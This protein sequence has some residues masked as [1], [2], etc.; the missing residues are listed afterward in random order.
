MLLLRTDSYGNHL[1]NET[2]ARTNLYSKGHSLIET[3]DHGFTI[4][5]TSEEST[6]E[7]VLANLNQ[8]S[9]QQESGPVWLLKTDSTGEMV[10]DYY[11]GNEGDRSSFMTNVED[12]GYLITGRT[13]DGDIFL[14]VVPELDWIQ[15]PV[16]Q[17]IS[18][19]SILIYQLEATSFA[20]LL[21]DVNNTGFLIDG[22]GILR[23]ATSLEPGTYG[24]SIIVTDAVGNT[25][26]AEIS[27]AVNSE[28]T[29]PTTTGGDPTLLILA[30]AGIGGGV[31]IVLL[32]VLVKKRGG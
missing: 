1:W 5:G 4:V 31:A 11:L 20:P 13:N 7:F 2:F 26:T 3:R 23:N 16:N 32:V 12:G 25:L 30:V 17:V 29:T 19:N 21:W 6:P 8:L 15:T 24:L 22:D 9:M 28:S 18:T 27:V 10:W 14:W